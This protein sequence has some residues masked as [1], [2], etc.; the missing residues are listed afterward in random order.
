MKTAEEFYFSEH[1]RQELYEYFVDQHGIQLLDSDFIE[2]QRY[3]SLDAEDYA[4][5]TAIKTIIG[6]F[7]YSKE[8]AEEIYNSQNQMK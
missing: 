4:K 7:D 2:L 6:F 3:V 5:E 8:D 1:L